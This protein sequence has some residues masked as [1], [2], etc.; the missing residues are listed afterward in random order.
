MSMEPDV[1]VSYA[2]ARTGVPSAAS[3]R[4]WVAAALADRDAPS[5]V[6]I[7]IVGSDEGRELNRQYRGKDY[8]TN[9]LSFPAE[10]PEGLPD[11]VEL[12]GLGDLVL[13]ADVVAREA[14]EQSKR[15]VDHYAHLTVHGVLHLLGWDHLEDA[16]AEAMEARER[17]ILSRLGIADP[18]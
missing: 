17:Q 3:F 9:V 13:C 15:P 2:T 16:E 6:A 5:E 18:Y 14:A 7:R 8:A 10:R 1:S 12:P 11:D 4:K